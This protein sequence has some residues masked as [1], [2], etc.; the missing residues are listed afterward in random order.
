MLDQTT[1]Q[2]FTADLLGTD[3]ATIDDLAEV[4]REQMTNGTLDPVDADQIIA[5]FQETFGIAP[6]VRT[7]A[8]TLRFVP[9]DRGDG[10]RWDN[11]LNWDSDDLPGTDRRR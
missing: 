7:E 9:D 11:R 4:L 2:R 10:V 6:D 3:T 5:Y 1:I 8:A